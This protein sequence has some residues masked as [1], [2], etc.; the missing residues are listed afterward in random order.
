[1]TSQTDSLQQLQAL[2]VSTCVLMTRFIDGHHCPKLAQSIV[3][4]L[5]QLLQSSAAQQKMYTDLLE[6]WQ[7]VAEQLVEQQTKREKIAVRY[8]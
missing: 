2:H 3:R 4:K 6:H 1:M 5:H 8:H 7:K